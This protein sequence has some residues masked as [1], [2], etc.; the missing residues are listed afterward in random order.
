M[1]PYQ[2][3]QQRWKFTLLIFAALIA[4]ASL[5]YTHYLVRNL[6]KSERTK[7]EVWAMST[8][9]I[10]TMPDV[11]DEMITFIYAVRDSLS[12]PAIIADAQDSIIYWRDLDSTKTNIREN[13]SD[14]EEVESGVEYDPAY[15]TRQLAIMKKSHP[16]I[17]INL[18]YGGGEWFVYYKDS[19]LLNQLRFFPYVQLTLIAIFLGI[20][21]TVFNSIRKSEQNLVWVGMAKEAAHQ[22]GTPISSLMAW[23]ELVRAKFDA[24]KDPLLT[25]MENDVK[26]L[27]VV[28]DRFSKIGSTPVL[29]SHTVYKAVVDFVNYFKVRTSDKI[30]FNVSGDMQVQAMLNVPLFDWVLENLLKNAANAIESAGRIDIVISENIAKEQI[31]IDISDT[32]KGIPR[33]QFDAV[34]LPGFTTR[35]RGWGLG[36]SLTKRM[37]DYHRGQIFVKESEIEKGTTFR[38][39]LPSNQTYEPAQI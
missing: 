36:L 9:S 20:A 27:E 13:G 30:V 12:L 34:F 33:A 11:D 4:A 29:Q 31:F 6:S 16:P 3:N 1:N 18:P 23:L 7:A 38:I 8:R 39:I 19:L 15:F 35:K 22:L 10:I 5:L 37:I 28:A 25:E 24:E 14:E 26:R 21:Y 17:I 2:Y 32:G